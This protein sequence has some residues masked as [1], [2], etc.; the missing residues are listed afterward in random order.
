MQLNKYQEKAKGTSL[1]RTYFGIRVVTYTDVIEII[2]ISKSVKVRF[3]TLT[4]NKNYTSTRTQITLWAFFNIHRP[5]RCSR[6][7]KI[8]FVLQFFFLL[9]LYTCIRVNRLNTNHTNVIYQT[10]FE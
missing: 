10:V 3:V 7:Q 2:L 9:Y 5:F 4:E 1:R 8:S 6:Y